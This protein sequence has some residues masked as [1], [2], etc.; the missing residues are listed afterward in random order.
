MEGVKFDWNDIGSIFLEQFTGRAHQLL[1]GQKK[2]M[3]RSQKTL[4]EIL[5]RIQTEPTHVRLLS[6]KRVRR[7]KTLFVCKLENGWGK[8]QNEWGGW[9]KEGKV[10]NG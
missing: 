7:V 10:G 9:E 3:M 1:L 4:S 5:R 2:M 8:A 6:Q